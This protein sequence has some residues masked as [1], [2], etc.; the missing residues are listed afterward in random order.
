MPLTYV[1]S[2]S[3]V[4]CRLSPPGC[5]DEVSASPASRAR[6]PRVF[7]FGKEGKVVGGGH[8]EPRSGT[9]QLILVTAE[10]SRGSKVT[11]G[12]FV[13]TDRWERERWKLELRHC[14]LSNWNQW[15]VL[16]SERLDG[17]LWIGVDHLSSC[18]LGQRPKNSKFVR[19]GKSSLRVSRLCSARSSGD[20]IGSESGQPHFLPW[21]VKSMAFLCQ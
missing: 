4:A 14:R 13:T 9:G 20:D 18:V 11:P 15:A 1:S 2:V 7:N 21:P 12:D 16:L 5:F 10:G 17:R 19:K 6:D 8:L 3:T